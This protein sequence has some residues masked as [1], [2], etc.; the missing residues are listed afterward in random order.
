MTPYLDPFVEQERRDKVA[1]IDQ[2]IILLD[3]IQFGTYFRKEGEPN[4]ANRTF[5]NE[6]EI[7]RTD[8]FSG[9]F[10]FDYDHKLFR[11][12]VRKILRT[13]F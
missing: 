7:R 3:A 11:I 13:P 9:E 8:T 10:M 1:A 6:Y 5:S 4:T 2:V 12:E